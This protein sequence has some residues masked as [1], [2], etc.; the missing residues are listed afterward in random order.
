MSLPAKLTRRFLAAGLVSCVFAGLQASAQ[1]PVTTREA[2]QPPVAPVVS[3]LDLEQCIALGFQRQPALAA[4][5]ASV[6]AAHAGARAVDRLLIP[7][8]FM[9][10]YQLRR[11]QSHLGVTIADAGLTQAE[12]ET[13]Y[14]ITRNYF[15]LQFIDSQGKVIDEVISNLTRARKRAFQ[16]YQN[17]TPESKFTKID[18]DQIDIGLATINAKKAQVDNGREKAKAALRE[19][20][21]LEYD[22]PLEVAPFD[23]TELVKKTPVPVKDDKGKPLMKDGKEVTVTE[24]RPLYSF[25]KK[26][27]VASAIANRGELVQASTGLQVAELEVKAQYRKIFGLRNPTF[28]AAGDVHSKMVPQSIHN[29]EY[30]PGGFAPEWPTILVGNRNDRTAR[31]EALTGRSAA[32]VDKAVSLVSLD[33]EAQYFKWQEAITEVQELSAI[34]DLARGLPARIEKLNPGD[35]TSR[36]IIDAN[37]TAITVR[38]QLNDALHM[39]AL[40]LA[41]IERAT[42][43]AFRIFPCPAP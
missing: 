7:R 12:W 3:P 33:V 30:R 18:I 35:F 26:N 17:P 23:L 14:A 28:A 41:G 1:E 22:Y 32:V 10:D 21:G 11:Q 6:N 9:R 19:A 38:T 16:L 31:A 25:D 15:T 13:R 5:H 40:A 20:M 34:Q 27:L 8:L 24:Y 39:H 4:A 37:V 2:E 43:G 36:A 42:A 29:G